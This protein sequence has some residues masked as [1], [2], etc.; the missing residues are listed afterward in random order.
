MRRLGSALLLT[1]L[2]V[3]AALAVGSFQP[4]PL[5]VVE[6]YEKQCSSCHGQ[7]GAMFEPGFEKKYATADS[8]RE[9]V[10]SMP[11]VSQMRGEQVGVLMAYVRA[12]SRGEVF[13]IWT[14]R[15]SRVLEGEV[16]PRGASLR[17]MARGKV[18][19]VTR[20]SPNR[21]RIELPPGVKVEDV[22]ITAQLQGKASTLLLRQGAYTHTR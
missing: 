22:R 20:L 5:R 7:E 4:A 13:L 9:I 10:E 6:T 18:L 2:C 11:G 21:W 15:Q 12:I 14:D 16:S 8:L 19:P 17:A 1:S 3:I